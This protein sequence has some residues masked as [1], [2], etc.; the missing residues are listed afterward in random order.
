MVLL[1]VFAAASVE[2]RSSR[3]ATILGT[4][5][6]VLLISAILQRRIHRLI[7][8]RSALRR[9]HHLFFA[10]ELF[11]LQRHIKQQ[12]IVGICEIKTGGVR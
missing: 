2:R 4:A 11:Q 5:L 3:Q 7:R 8:K 12:S 10:A 9:P 1:R 6:G